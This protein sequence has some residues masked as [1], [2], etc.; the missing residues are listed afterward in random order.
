MVAIWL[1]SQLNHLTPSVWNHTQH[2]TRMFDLKRLQEVWPTLR[3]QDVSELGNRCSP[4]VTPWQ[5]CAVYTCRCCCLSSVP[6]TAQINSR[7]AVLWRFIQAMYL[8]PKMTWVGGLISSRDKVEMY[9]FWN[10]FTFYCTNKVTVNSTK[11]QM[12]SPCTNPYILLF[13]LRPYEIV[14]EICLQSMSNLFLQ[15]NSLSN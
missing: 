2:I 7:E 4:S 15:S 14:I 6:L 8:L 1:K 5:G 9:V 3:G 10:W 12:A 13:M 11:R